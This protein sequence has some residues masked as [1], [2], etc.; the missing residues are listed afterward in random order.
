VTLEVHKYGDAMVVIRVLGDDPVSLDDADRAA[1]VVEAAYEAVPNGW[2]LDEDG[3][4][5][6]LRDVR[7]RIT[8]SV[9]ACAYLDGQV[10]GCITYVPPGTPLDEHGGTEPSIR[11]LAVGPSAAGRGVGAALVRWAI[12]R[13][14]AER[15]GRLSL[16]TAEPMQIAQAMY[17]K[18]GFRREPDRDWTFRPGR[19]LLAYAL[20]IGSQPTS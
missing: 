19:T 12:E 8:S 3:Y 20:E 6:E 14:S 11:M 15:F 16:Y 9:V 13:A 2:P 1:D 4:R 5:A 17:R 18:L 7:G 10:V